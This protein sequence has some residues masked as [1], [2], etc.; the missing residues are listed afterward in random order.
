LSLRVVE[1]NNPRAGKGEDGFHAQVYTTWLDLRLG[2]DELGNYASR[3]G[4][5]AGEKHCENILQGHVR[6]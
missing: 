1:I 4:D 2:T 6:W 5:M 3:K